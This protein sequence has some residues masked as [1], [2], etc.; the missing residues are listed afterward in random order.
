MHHRRTNRFQ[1]DLGGSGG[2]APGA[3][4]LAA[5]PDQRQALREHALQIR[6]SRDLRGKSFDRNIFGE[7]AWEILL[8][9]Y[10]IDFDRRRLSTREL[11]KLANLALT[12]TL[13]WIDFLEEQNLIGRKP[14]PFDQRMVYV[15]LSD[16]ARAAMDNYLLQMRPAEMFGPIA[17]D[18]G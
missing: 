16:K 12:T 15:E 18:K 8:T 7:P 4:G 10:T 5:S 3:V 1:D 13:R 9:L 6:H 11:C 14:N 2:N 17:G